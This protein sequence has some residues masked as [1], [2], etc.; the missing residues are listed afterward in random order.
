MTDDR[1]IAEEVNALLAELV[2]N[3]NDIP[4]VDPKLDVTAQMYADVLHITRKSALI[5][6]V[7]LKEKG[8]LACHKARNERGY[9]VYAYRKK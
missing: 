8:Q 4:D 1:I 2:T 6:L 7:S 9:V 5:R 3:Y